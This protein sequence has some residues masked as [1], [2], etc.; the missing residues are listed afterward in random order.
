MP[1]FVYHFVLDSNTTDTPM[2]GNPAVGIWRATALPAFFCGLLLMPDT[3]LLADQPTRPECVAPAKPGGGFDL[4][5]RIAQSGLG[6]VLE[7]PMQVTFMPR[8]VGAVAFALFNTTRTSDPNAIVAF[9]TGSLLNIVT[10]KFGQWTEN[11]IRFVATIGTD[12]GAVIVRGDSPFTSLA[13]LMDQLAESPASV[14]I[15]A[16]G[17]VGSQDWMKAA[18]LLRSVGQDPRNMRYV[19]FDGGGEASTAL[20]GGHIDVYTGDIGEMN[21]HIG[22]DK[23]RILAVLSDT[24]LGE[25]FADIR[26]ASEQGYDVVWRILRGFYVGRDVSNEAYQFWVDAFD[27]MFDTAEF[28]SLQRELGLF[29]FNRSGAGVEAE[30]VEEVGQMRQLASEM[31]LLR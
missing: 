7:Q 12:F 9:S 21:A 23:F 27:E 13:T 26:T 24:R 30:I 5:C 8:G 28:A 1:A 3:P 4:T 11:D 17:S 19:S 18:L 15:G 6:E 10:G 20:L 31:G 2:F 22:D 14:V 29:P 16:G 25:P